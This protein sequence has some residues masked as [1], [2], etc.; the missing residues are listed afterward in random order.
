MV[1]SSK[2]TY[3]N[4]LHFPRLL[5]PVPLTLRQATFNQ[6]LH[7]RPIG[8]SVSISCGVT[9]KSGSVSCVVNCSFPLGPDAQKVLFVPF[10]ILMSKI[11]WFSEVH[12][13]CSLRPH[14]RS[15]PTSLQFKSKD[16]IQYLLSDNNGNELEISKTKIENPKTH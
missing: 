9:G 10:R 2:T 4:K 15:S 1:T 7:R 14:S 3:T 11:A 13:E 8:R 6:H 5:P 12:T 16:I